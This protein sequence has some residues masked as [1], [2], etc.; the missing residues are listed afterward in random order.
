M[1][2]TGDALRNPVTDE[3]LRFLETA[4][5]T[6]GEHV[7]VKARIRPDGAVAAAH[8]HPWASA[9]RTRRPNPAS[10][11]SPSDATVRG[12]GHRPAPATA[13]RPGERR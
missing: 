9:R 10:R 6:G 4:T 8:L 1:I 3:E 12:A 5:D 11:S 7:L 13:R 2:R